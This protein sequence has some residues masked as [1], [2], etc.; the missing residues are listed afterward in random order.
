MN[1]DL[2]TYRVGS[3]TGIFT[4]ALLASPEWSNSIASLQAF[5][6]SSGMR[7]QFA[8]TINDRRVSQSEGTFDN[9]PGV[10]DNSAD[11]LIV[12]QAFHWCPNYASAIQEFAR[13]LKPG[14]PVALVWNLED[15]E[16]VAWIAQLRDRI[17][18]HEEGTPQFRLELWRA[19]FEQPNYKDLFEAPT[20][21]QWPYI[22][23]GTAEITI[24]RACSKSYIAILPEDKKKQV[25]E[26]I[27]AI[28]DRGDDMKWIDREQGVFEYAYRSYVVVFKKK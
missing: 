4:R 13:V 3:G 28:L 19:A 8:K 15:R 1:H 26:D 7:D 2:T 21:K 23:P 12:A 27:K 20:E 9:L 14:A 5:E 25:Q 11:I 24:G 18:K 22:I 6:P 17:E 10:P 16:A